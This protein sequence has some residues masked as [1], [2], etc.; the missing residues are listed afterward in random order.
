MSNEIQISPSSNLPTPTPWSTAL[1]STRPPQQQSG[2]LKVHQLLRG[3]YGVAILLAA[4]FA[5]AGAAAGFLLPRP[6]YQSVGL[7]EIK[8]VTPTLDDWDRVMPMYQY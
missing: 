1:V 5:A 4:M 3:R 6:S 2:L 7:I 8:P